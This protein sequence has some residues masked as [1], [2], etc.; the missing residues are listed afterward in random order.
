V[1]A[2]LQRIKRWFAISLLVVTVAPAHAETPNDLTEQV[3]AAIVAFDYRDISP[4]ALS[5]AEQLIADS[6]AVAM[7]AHHIALMDD[8]EQIF[9]VNGGD[10]LILHS[11]NRGELLEAV[12]LNSMASN[13]LDFDDSHVETG[14]PGAS[15]I[16]PA[17]VLAARFGKSRE[18][19]IEAVVAG[20]EFNIR[21]ARAVFNYP[22][23]LKGPWSSATLQAFGT[24]VTAGKL[25]DLDR[26]TL[27]RALFFAAAN[28]PLPVF[29]KVGLL[30][31]QT[32]SALKNNYGQASHSAVL[33][34]LTARAGAQAD[35]T[36]L[37]GDQGLWRMMAAKEFHPEN[38]LKDLGARWEILGVQIKPYA[39]CRWMH[40]S[41]DALIALRD[42]IQAGRIKRIDVYTYRIAVN[43]LSGRE[44]SDL[45]ALQFSLPHIFGLV[46]SGES[47]IYL[48]ESGIA[49]QGALE[50]SRKV[51]VH[52][53]ENYEAIF[54]EN[55]LPSK[56]VVTL[57]D[58][59]RLEKEVLVPL[60]SE[61]NPIGAS[62]HREKV[63]TLI[64]SSP[65]DDARSYA[66][67]MIDRSYL[68]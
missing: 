57:E 60:G 27:Q 26:E 42:D 21:W 1:N 17:L 29:Q 56:V 30:P 46:L 55:M 31:G 4:E 49:H 16:Q 34:V 53:D 41:L 6:V 39:A 2:L 54:H 52:F 28:M 68:R 20:Y 59:S 32:T 24:L 8:L 23:K 61:T 11:G 38:V 43:A 10:S 58:G 13:M 12:Y 45:L 50:I 44:P 22:E 15:I 40:S 35:G 36:V 65:H 67:R 62:Q 51:H 7:G 66:W 63:R 47:L 18:D 19:L 25:L 5:K 14:H 48:R 33:A 37:D 64:D 3:A 9:E